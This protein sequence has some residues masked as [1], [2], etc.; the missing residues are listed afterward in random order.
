V[1]HRK[2]DLEQF[3]KEKAASG[4]RKSVR[5]MPMKKTLR[6]FLNVLE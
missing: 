2:V 6:N 3:L 4:R 5:R 1:K